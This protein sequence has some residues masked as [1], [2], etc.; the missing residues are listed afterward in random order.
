LNNAGVASIKKGNLDK[1]S[2]YLQKAAAIAPN[3][4]AIENNIGVVA[5]KQKDL[6]KAE[7]QFKKA[8]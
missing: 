8:R 5:A 7:A 6:K 4:G 1:A 3:N 2:N